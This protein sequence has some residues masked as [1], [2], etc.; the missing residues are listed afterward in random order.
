MFIK[1][2]MAMTGDSLEA[3]VIMTTLFKLHSLVNVLPDLWSP[4]TDKFVSDKERLNTFTDELDHPFAQMFVRF[5]D[6]NRRL[7]LKT[8]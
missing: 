6:F 3:V 4:L 1:A 7:I 8:R 5:R 2:V